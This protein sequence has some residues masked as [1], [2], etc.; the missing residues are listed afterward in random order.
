MQPPIPLI[1]RF[2][3]RK[4]GLLS[5][6]KWL[7]GCKC[8]WRKLF[9]LGRSQGIKVEFRLGRQRLLYNSKRKPQ[10]LKNPIL[11][12]LPKAEWKLTQCKVV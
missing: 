5:Y 11:T 8:L 4:D 10:H 6:G 12:G 7:K 3:G 1:L 2:L 9:H